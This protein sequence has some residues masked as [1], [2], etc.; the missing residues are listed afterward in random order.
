[1]SEVRKTFRGCGI[2]VNY[3]KAAKCS[4]YWRADLDNF[5]ITTEQ[6]GAEPPEGY[7]GCAS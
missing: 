4:G 2:T 3:A 5:G 6:M 7:S 1:M